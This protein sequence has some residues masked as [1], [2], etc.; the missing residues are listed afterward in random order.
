MVSITSINANIGEQKNYS[1]F[2]ININL[3]FD[4]KTVISVAGKIKEQDDIWMCLNKAGCCYNWEFKTKPNITGK[5]LF[6]CS[7]DLILGLFPY[8]YDYEKRW[9]SDILGQ[10]FDVKVPVSIANKIITE[11][12]N[13]VDTEIDTTISLTSDEHHIRSPNLDYSYVSDYKVMGKRGDLVLWKC[14][15]KRFV[16][17]VSNNYIKTVF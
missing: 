14:S 5:V 1:I 9:P 8:Y 11:I 16:K 13:C 12:V 17:V 6:K 2:S 7:E 4:K 10:R 15:F 3:N